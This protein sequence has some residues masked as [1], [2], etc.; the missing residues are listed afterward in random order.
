[1]YFILYNGLL[2]IKQLTYKFFPEIF[3]VLESILSLITR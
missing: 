2:L 3:N 1:M